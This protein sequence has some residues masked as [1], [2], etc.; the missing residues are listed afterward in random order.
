MPPNL[1]E[2]SYFIMAIKPDLFGLI[3]EFKTEVAT[4]AEVIR[5]N[6]PLAGQAALRMLFERSAED[7]KRV[8]AVGYLDVDDD[9]ISSLK[10]L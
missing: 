6:A 8:F 7:G 3:D 5:S 10:K 1:A 2:F 4:Y 9:V